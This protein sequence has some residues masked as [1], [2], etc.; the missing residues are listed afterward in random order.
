MSNEVRFWRNSAILFLI[1]L[2]ISLGFVTRGYYFK[3]QIDV[4]E[5][6][7]QPA[8]ELDEIDTV[9]YGDSDG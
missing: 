4:L 2:L 6:I 3:G 9:D 8:V 5:Q 1:L 7:R